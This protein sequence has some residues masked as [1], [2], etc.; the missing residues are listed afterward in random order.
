MIAGN[1]SLDKGQEGKN[2]PE[3]DLSPHHRKQEHLK[4]ATLSKSWALLSAH[5]PSYSG[6]KVVSCTGKG[7]GSLY[8][9]YQARTDE[10]EGAIST[11]K[12]TPFILAPC[13]G[14][15]SIIDSD[16]GI[17]IRTIRNGYAGAT[18]TMNSLNKDEDNQD[19]DDENEFIDTEAIMSFALAPNDMDLVT[20]CR[21]N[22]LRH[23]DLSS[24]PTDANISSSDGKG[25]HP[26]KKVLGKSGHQLPI[27]HIEFHCS[28]IFFATGSVDGNVKIWDLRGGYATHSF[29]YHSRRFSFGDRGGLR[30]SVTS[31]AWYPDITK[32]WLTVG[33]EDGSIRIHDLREEQIKSSDSIKYDGMSKD[34]TSIMSTKEL[35]D[36][37]APVTCMLWAKKPST[38]EG[39]DTFLSTGRDSVINVWS[40]EEKIIK[41]KGRSEKK[42]KKTNDTEDTKTIITYNRLHTVPVY[43]QIEGMQL[44]ENIP[45][46]SIVPIQ[47]SDILVATAGN[48]GIVRIWKG[49]RP[50]M[51]SG[52]K[53]QTSKLS[54]ISTQSASSAFGHQRGGYVGLLLRSLKRADGNQDELIAVDAEHNISFLSLFDQAKPATVMLNTTR[55]IVGHNDEILDLKILP[56][57]LGVSENRKVALATNTS[58][59]RIFELGTFSCELLNGHTNTVIAID[60]SPCGKY[61][62]SCGKDNTMRLWCLQRNCC[63]AVA[64]GHTE[65]LGSTALSK[66][67][68]QY[69]VS[70]KSAT[71]GRGAFVVTV[72][73]DKTLKRWNLPGSSILDNTSA[74]E[75]IN[76]SVFCSVRAHKKDINIVSININDELIATGSQD[77]TVKIWNSTDLKLI[78]ELKGHK[79]GIW[80]CQFSPYDRV[81]CSCS[82]DK[83]CKLWSLT[84]FS[85]IR[86]FQGHVSSTLRARF[87]SG[88]LQ[89]MSCD[90]DGVVRLWGIRSNECVFS[91]NVHND[92]VW[93][94]D[95]TQDGILVTGGADSQLKVFTDST[96]ELEE[97]KRELDEQ[98]I[99][100]E[101]KLA[102]H[103][104]NNEFESALHIALSLDKPRQVLKV[105]ASIIE[106]DYTNENATLQKIAKSW[107]K[108]HLSQI[109]QYCRDWNTRARNSH[110]AMLTVHAII[111]SIR[112]DQLVDIEGLTTVL[113]GIAPYADRHFERLD[114]LL[115]SSY[116]L[117]FTLHS[118]GDLE[119][120]ENIADFT[121]WEANQKLI[122]PPKIIDGKIEI[123][124]R[125]T[126]DEEDISEDEVM[127]IGDSDSESSLLSDNELR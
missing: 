70:G 73:R 75:P 22:I 120:E 60:C 26:V 47:K 93:A 17:K 13:G 33:R 40:M 89:M 57:T 109:L 6:G 117:D 25:S 97:Q 85:C 37:D 95:I 48:K 21:N 46:N 86:S 53:Q 27:S 59:V 50:N 12:T 111:A 110:V 2:W 24:S 31:L 98:N 80:D 105:L 20:S 67:M 72:S 92:K 61:L 51:S 39:F 64:T 124:E 100:M 118:M 77:K 66:K 90:A 32:L 18:V 52:I 76:L 126:I 63:I 42:R 87:L 84:D 115:T 15:L 91:M 58:Q 78:G 45:C 83:S 102:N 38:D 113:D 116:L 11:D 65:A 4:T 36:H 7:I 79:R 30:G 44:L 71:S 114:K 9:L 5:T 8:G 69:D 19:D 74:K 121:A 68:H 54:C 112:A 108:R 55:T 104:R 101:Q 34:P 62:A 122:M 82:G 28:G 125:R 127:T 16:R 23:Y 35:I 14:D 29:R 119:M 3:S 43:E 10:E 41:S 1:L 99:L 106:N 81:L 94:L 49:S 56:Q 88:G 123:G 96:K 107:K 103:L